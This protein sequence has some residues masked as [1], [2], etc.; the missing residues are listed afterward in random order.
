MKK[1]LGILVVTLIVVVASGA[2]QATLFTFDLTGVKGANK[3]WIFD[4]KRDDGITAPVTSDWNHNVVFDQGA[5]IWGNNNL[6]APLLNIDLNLANT[7]G[8]GKLLYA[9]FR[10]SKLLGWG[11]LEFN[12]DA[13]GK[14]LGVKQVVKD[15]YLA[16][17]LAKTANWR[18]GH[19]VDFTAISGGG[20]INGK[21]QVPEPATML[22]LGMGLIGVSVY[23]RKRFKTN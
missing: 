19:K 14:P 15:K 13:D 1:V 23:A 11:R 5:K 12:L 22:L 2:A 9:I 18:F 10:N 16:A 21:H 3:V 20:D 8:D 6:S 7:G 17:G 4:T